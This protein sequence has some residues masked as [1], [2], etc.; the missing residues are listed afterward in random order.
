MKEDTKKVIDDAVP[1]KGEKDKRVADD[2]SLPKKYSEEKVFGE[3]VAEYY[4]V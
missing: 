1:L 4:P 2:F 3:V